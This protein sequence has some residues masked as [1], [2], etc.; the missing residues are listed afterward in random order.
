MLHIEDHIIWEVCK[1]VV[2]TGDIP[3]M[4]SFHHNDKKKL[5]IRILF[6]ICIDIHLN[7]QLKIHFRHFSVVFA[8]CV[9]ALFICQP[10][11]DYKSCVSAR[12]WES[13][14]E[15]KLTFASMNMP[16]FMCVCVRDGSCC[17]PLGLTVVKDSK[18][19]CGTGLLSLPSLC[20][21]TSH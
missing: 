19:V 7:R 8:L 2:C 21:F 15:W 3:Y 13:E 1:K 20:Y 6:P 17:H 18:A 5:Y 10:V 4:F 16:A 14:G 12:V 9:S 11:D